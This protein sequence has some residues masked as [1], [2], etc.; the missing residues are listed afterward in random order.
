MRETYPKNEPA[1]VSSHEYEGIQRL[2]KV[3]NRRKQPYTLHRACAAYR[4]TE[5]GAG[6]PPQG[7]ISAG[8]RGNGDVDDNAEEDEA[9][10]PCAGWGEGCY[11]WSFHLRVCVRWSRECVSGGEG[12]TMPRDSSA[13]AFMP[14]S[15]GL[16]SA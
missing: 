12:V 7:E 11:L 1:P 14:M 13:S 4:I 8:R 16:T 2:E 5:G 15:L 10:E 9:G 6:Y 3:N